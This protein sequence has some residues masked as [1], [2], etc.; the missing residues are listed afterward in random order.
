MI[1]SIGARGRSTIAEIASDLGR[2]ADTLYYHVAA[3]VKAGVVR[4]VDRAR[5]GTRFAAVYDLA[6][7][8]VI[9]ERGG[10]GGTRGAGRAAADDA[11]VRVVAAALRLGQ[12]D[13]RD[14]IAGGIARTR[15]T[16]TPG[17]GAAAAGSASAICPRCRSTWM[18]SQ[19]CCGAAVMTRRISL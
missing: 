8:P 12:R 19:R 17:R 15:F 4:E 9:V 16:A 13:F 5:A 11:V 7:R 10:G 18:R 2:P 6:G 1:D 14:A 3:L